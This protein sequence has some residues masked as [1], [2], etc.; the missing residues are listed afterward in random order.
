MVKFPFGNPEDSPGF[1][2]WQTTV[3]WQRLIKKVLDPYN[4]SHA[5]FVILS[6]TLWFEH[7]GQVPTQIMIV[8]KSK[9]DKMTVSKSLK[10]LVT[11]GFIARSENEQDTRSKIVRLTPQGKAMAEKLLPLIIQIDQ[12][13]F[14][15][16]NPE[17]LDH[18]MALLGALVA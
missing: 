9:L 10:K 6:L 3:T 18:F 7:Q 2:L 5:Q 4:V 13:F 14:K 17:E 12:K 15:P 1:L 16:F 11:Q 8:N